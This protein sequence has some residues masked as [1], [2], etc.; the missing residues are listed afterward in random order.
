MEIAKETNGGIRIA[1][2]G[3]VHISHLRDPGA[4][5]KALKE[6]V[7]AEKAD[8]LI[9][10]GDI[11]QGGMSGKK[12]AVQDFLTAHPSTYFVLGNHDLWSSKDYNGVKYDP[13]T[14]MQKHLKT[15][16][17]WGKP[18]EKSWT[19]QD[20]FY[21]EKGVAIV[22]TMGFPDFSHPYFKPLEESLNREGTTNDVRYMKILPI[23]WLHFTEPM[24]KAFDTRLKKV[25]E[26]G[27]KTVIVA[28]HYSIFES[29]CRLTHDDIS[30]YFFDHW[31]GQRVLEVAKKHPDKKF[32]CLSGHSHNF[33]WGELKMEAENVFSFGL[34]TEYGE[35]TIY[36]FDTG[37]DINQERK[38]RKIYDSIP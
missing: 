31:I 13:P 10:L 17:K 37:L 21:A 29:Q 19:D 6:A 11:S 34:K 27:M 24:H 30:P 26:S 35:V 38:G 1:V 22:G 7:E 9:V 8:F 16:F 5:A 33:C 4:G 15:Y 20:T 23:G 25:L 18:I 32:W 28:T 2:T 3:D 14:A 36:P 12:S